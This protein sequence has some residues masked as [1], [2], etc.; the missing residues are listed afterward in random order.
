MRLRVLNGSN[1]RGYRLTASDGRTFHVIGSDGGLLENPVPMTEVLVNAGER[2]EIMVDLRDGKPV[3]F[4][5]LPVAQL[6]MGLPP[7]DKPFPLF[8]LLP[9]GA[10][11]VGRLPD[12]L[13]T[14]PALPTQLPEVSQELS[15]DMYKDKEGMGQI[16][17]TGIMATRGDGTPDPEAVSRMIEF[18]VNGPALEKSVQFAA[19]G[20]NGK[21]FALQRMGFEASRN[22]D[23]RWRIGEGSDA[24]LHPVHVHGCQYRILKING[25]PPP[26]HMAGWKDTVPISSGG[27]AEI[28]VNFPHAAAASAPYMAHC[29]ILEHEDSGMMT[30]FTVA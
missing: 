24:M 10:D 20:I 22:Q 17:A 18:I 21:S 16:K 26:A 30:Q 7:F 6:G 28:L 11:G 5:S 12:Q 2:Y 3:D 8:T 9:D 19:N 27:S 13:T 25:K 29:H 15:M 23:L 14:L 4:L 1:A